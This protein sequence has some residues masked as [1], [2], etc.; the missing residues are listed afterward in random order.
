MD[1]KNYPEYASIEKQIRAARIER[2]P[3]IANAVAGFV[4]GIWAAIQAPPAA[5][6]IVAIDRRRE[7]RHGV[8]RW[9][10]R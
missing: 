5:P 1:I 6:A 7:S 9:A 2:V 10:P 8:Q 3:A 4:T